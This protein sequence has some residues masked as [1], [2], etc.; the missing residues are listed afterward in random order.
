[1]LPFWSAIARIQAFGLD[2][3]FRINSGWRGPPWV[4]F[5]RSEKI[6]SVLRIYK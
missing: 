1:L 5:A 6:A 2:S 3:V 4:L